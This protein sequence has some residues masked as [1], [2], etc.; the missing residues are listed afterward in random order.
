MNRD[1]LNKEYLSNK[2][3]S[4]GGKNRV[5]EYYKD[6]SNSAIDKALSYN[7]IYTRFKQHR[8]SKKYSPIY[9]HKK[10][11]LFQSDV[12]FFTD[13]TL[14]KAN[15]G[16]QYLHCTIDAFTKMAWIY[17]L[18]ENTCKS[19]LMCIK[20][21]LRKC[22]DKPKRINSDRGSEFTCNKFEKFMKNS[23]I[24]HYLSYSIRKCPIIERFNLT[25]Q[26]LLYKL[27]SAHNSHEWTKFLDDAMRIYLNRKHRTIQ[28]T[29]LEAE[30]DENQPKL[31]VL[32]QMKYVKAGEK[33]KKP[34]YKIGDSVRIWKDRGQFHRGYM[35]D[36][37]REYFTI[38]KVLNNLPVPR[39]K[40]KEQNGENV[41]GSFFEDELVEYNSSPN[42]NHEIEKVI[43]A[44][45]KGRKKEYFVKFKGWPDS[46][47]EWVK[48][49]NIVNI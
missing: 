14:V 30:K 8:K 42:V 38:V 35:E 5:Y 22:G 44:R 27:M 12:T 4:F 9:V 43:K 20:D 11:E 13:K 46:Y 2:P 47:N 24:K 39:Y 29:P 7:D 6:I 21:I 49:S 28:M 40:I 17:P 15:H 25:I 36:Y 45:G 41:I 18:K 37:T 34:K 48:A 1:K 26:Q 31:Q 23:K 33:V 10:R 32:Y 3:H 16:Y 19:S